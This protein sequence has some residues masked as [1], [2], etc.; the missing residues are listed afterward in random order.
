MPKTSHLAVT[1]AA[2]GSPTRLEIVRRLAAPAGYADLVLPARRRD[3]AGSPDRTMTRQ[4]VRRHLRIL[5]RA[6]LVRTVRRG[7]SV[8]FVRDEGAIRSAGAALSGI[9]GGGDGAP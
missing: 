3:A 8:A 1:L 4:A 5:E 2:L 9:C 6:G 7:R